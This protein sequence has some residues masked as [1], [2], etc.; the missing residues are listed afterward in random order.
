MAVIKSVVRRRRPAGNKPDSFELG[1]DKYSFPSG[2]VSRA[3]FIVFFFL[4]L[5]PV[6]LIFAPP[7]FAWAVTIALSRVL[8][9]RHHILDVLAGVALGILEGFLMKYVWLSEGFAIYVIQSITDER[10]DGGE[11]HV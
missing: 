2:H 8:L 3:V 6:N 1:P 11:Y 4:Y 7:L 9:R 10:F 5:Y